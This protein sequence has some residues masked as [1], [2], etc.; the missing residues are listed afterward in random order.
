MAGLVTTGLCNFIK[1]EDGKWKGVSELR[2][3][4]YTWW[5]GDG[6]KVV[7]PKELTTWQT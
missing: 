6:D 1:L 3:R 4:N 5:Q 2:F 7:G